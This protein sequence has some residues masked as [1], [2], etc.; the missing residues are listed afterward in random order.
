MKTLPKEDK[1]KVKTKQLLVKLHC[2]VKNQRHDFL[3]KLSTQLVEEYSVIC[4]EKLKIKQMV[5]D[6]NKTNL[7]KS[8]GDSGWYTF[9]QM[10]TYKAEE[11]G[12][13]VVEVDPAYTSQ[14]CSSCGS[15]VKKELSEREHNCGVCGLQ[16]PR[17]VNAAK[18]I[19]RIGMDS[20]SSR[21]A[22]LNAHL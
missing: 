8:I 3:H 19:L 6:S 10:L 14:M 20:L 1:K 17:D 18:N 2:K 16:L 7:N 9:K 4:C 15:I 13:L 5:E 12:T 21:N 22:T 11:A